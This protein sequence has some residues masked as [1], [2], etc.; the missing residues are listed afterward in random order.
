MTVLIGVAVKPAD[1]EL[2]PFLFFGSDSKRVQ[3][4]MQGDGTIEPGAVDEDYEKI[5]KINKKLLAI[6][7]LYPDDLHQ[8][9]IDFIKNND[10]NLEEL[11]PNVCQ[12][13]CNIIRNTELE[14]SRCTVIIGSCDNHDP[15]FSYIEVERQNIDNPTI[16]FA[17]T[18]KGNFSPIFSGSTTNTEDLQKNFVK[19]V[20]DSN[21]N[22]TVVK[23]SAIQYLTEAA[24]RHPETCNEV[25]QYIKLS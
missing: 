22:S 11:T 16:N 3:Y 10:T 24:K 23:N 5:T 14:T 9:L 19:R 6:S 7:G 12:F 15:K 18:A 13:I 25:I 4:I 1:K 17:V 2:K 21:F 8:N 20:N